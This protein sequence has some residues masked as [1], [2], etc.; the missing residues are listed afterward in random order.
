L[1]WL[2]RVAERWHSQGAEQCGAYQRANVRQLLPPVAFRAVPELHHS[3]VFTK[4]LDENTRLSSVGAGE[5]RPC[6][7]VK[8]T[9]LV[10]S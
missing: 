3:F 4:L 8:E 1:Y 6:G 2:L 5:D 7:F 9:D 10:L